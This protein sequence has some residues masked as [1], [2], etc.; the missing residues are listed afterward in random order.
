MPNQPKTPVRS[1]R[2]SD[3]IYLPAKA[4]AD[5]EGTTLSDVVRDA[6]VE[7]VGDDEDYPSSA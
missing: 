3:E 7:Y 4:K 6:L 1:F 5:A 2:I